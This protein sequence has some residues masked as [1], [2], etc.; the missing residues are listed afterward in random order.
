MRKQPNLVPAFGNSL[1]C[2]MKGALGEL[3]VA[4]DL[5]AHGYEV[6]RAMSPDAAFDLVASKGT[7]LLR[8]ECRCGTLNAKSG[9]IYFAKT[10][11][12]RDRALP[13]HYAVV[14]SGQIV[15]DPPLEDVC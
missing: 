10:T 13:D 14:L 15:Y 3:T 9:K 2:G 7:K 5:M 6:F 8:I 12:K 11:S 1:T 4:L